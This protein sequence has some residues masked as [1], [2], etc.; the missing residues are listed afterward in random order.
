MGTFVKA[1]LFGLVIAI[2]LLPVPVLI[3]YL[4]YRLTGFSIA[5]SVNHSILGVIWLLMIY[6]GFS[7]GFRI[8]YRN[9]LNKL[10]AEDLEDEKRIKLKNEIRAEIL[11]ELASQK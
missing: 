2:V 4:I 3:D 8:V 6:F 1:M 5:D 10:L 7:C 11:D 9:K